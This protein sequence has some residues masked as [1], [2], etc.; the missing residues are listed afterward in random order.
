MEDWVEVTVQ[1]PR[2]LVRRFYGLF[3]D[4][5]TKQQEQQPRP[6]TAR[7]RE[8]LLRVSSPGVRTTMLWL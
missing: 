1:V 8:L 5:S 2:H 3:G 6:R 7:P 4:S